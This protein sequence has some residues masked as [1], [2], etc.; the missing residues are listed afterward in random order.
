MNILVSNDSVSSSNISTSQIT[1]T[2]VVENFYNG[3]L[4]ITGVEGALDLPTEPI[5]PTV[6]ITNSIYL[7][8][9]QDIEPQAHSMSGQAITAVVGEPMPYE[10]VILGTAG[11]M[12]VVVYGGRAL[13]G[14]LSPR[15]VRFIHHTI[16][17]LQTEIDVTHIRAE[18]T[19]KRAK[20]WL[21]DAL[22]GGQRA[23]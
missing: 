15:T 17:N 4:G 22:G 2:F 1:V 14:S 13:T 6:P 19:I 23:A 18:R 21:Q 5:T 8:L 16:N 20:Q 3:M 9:I 10:A 12:P 11:I 7:P